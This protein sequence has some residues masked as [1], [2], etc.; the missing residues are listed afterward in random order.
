MDNMVVYQYYAERCLV[1]KEGSFHAAHQ[2]FRLSA[3]MGDD[4]FA[5]PETTRRLGLLLGNGSSR[6]LSDKF[7]YDSLY[8]IACDPQQKHPLTPTDQAFFTE[9][10][11]TNFEAVLSA[12]ATTRMVCA[13][14]NKE[15]GDVNERYQ[16]IRTSLI[17]AVKTV[18]V[19]FE[20]VPAVTKQYLGDVLSKYRYVYTINYDLLLYWAM[21]ET[22]HTIDDAPGDKHKHA[23]KDFLW[24]PDQSF[25]S[26]NAHEFED[27][28]SRVLYLHGALHLEHDPFGN[29]RKKGPEMAGPVYFRNFM[30]VAIG[31]R[32]SSVKESTRKNFGPSAEMIT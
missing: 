5:V 16:S 18:H 8:T 31:F 6:A 15:F 28:G 2:H 9:M 20:V 29:T 24:G 30:L 27:E 4:P 17:E 22:K 1:D 11:T 3:A 23:W 14:L 13:H 26:S 19:P 10:G 25:D 12:L 7:S 32:C 21:M